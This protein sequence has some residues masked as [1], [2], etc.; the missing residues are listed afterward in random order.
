MFFQW[1]TILTI[2]ISLWGFPV[3]AK[4]EASL[5]HEKSAS[6]ALVTQLPNFSSLAAEVTPGV[7]SILVDQKIKVSRPG[8]PNGFPFDFFFQPFG[9]GGPQAA[10]PQEYHNQGIGSGIVI[11]EDGLVLTNYHVVENADNIE[12]QFESADGGKEIKSAKILG[13]APDYDVALLQVQDA[14]QTPICYLGDSSA[15][16]IGDWVMAIGTPFGLSHS[17]SVGIISAKERRNIEPS[18]RAGLYDF[19]Q[20]DASI[21]PGNSGGPLINMRGEVIGINTAIN[22]AGSGIG[23]AIP[24]NMVKSMLPQLRATGE[25]ARSWIGIRIQPLTPALAQSYGLKKGEGALIAEIVPNGPA[26]KANLREGDIILKFN[27]KVVHQ[28]S[29][30][31]LWASM[32]GVGQE[33]ELTV[34][35]GGKTVQVHVKLERLPNNDQ[36][37]EDNPADGSENEIYGSVLGLSFMK[38]NNEPLRRKL[39]LE[40]AQKV[41]LVAKIDPDGIAARAGVRLGDVIISANERK[42]AHPR[43]LLH[44]LQK[45]PAKSVIRLHIARANA[46]LFIAIQKP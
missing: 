23:F 25:F 41:V 34:W 17:V 6:S 46:R 31:Q 14:A 4:K 30:L 33:A 43:E 29:D 15:V 44:Y 36:I 42:F 7:V 35:R 2:F 45:L 26:A 18:G 16:E 28:S 21:N 5:W 1:H 11:R 13:K 39:Q 32:G 37:D 3:H 27:G 19:L 12:V 38:L 8:L 9:P 24:I 40:S 10:P 20:T 22:A